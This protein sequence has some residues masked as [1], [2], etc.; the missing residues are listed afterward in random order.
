MCTG[1]KSM[2]VVLGCLINVGSIQAEQLS[3]RMLKNQGYKN[4]EYKGSSPLIS[5]YSLLL[6][7]PIFNL[8]QTL[9]AQ[10]YS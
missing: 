4:Q 7:L 5:R 10:R 3:Q 8:G 9:I 2:T 6:M 1:L